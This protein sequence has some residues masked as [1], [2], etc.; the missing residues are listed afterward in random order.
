MKVVTEYIFASLFFLLP[1]LLLF[2]VIR[3][4]KKSVTS[5]TIENKTAVVTKDIYKGM[6]YLF[7]SV[8][9]FCFVKLFFFSDHNNAGICYENMGCPF[10]V[11]L[12]FIPEFYFISIFLKEI[13]FFFQKHTTLLLWVSFVYTCILVGVAM[14]ITLPWFISGWYF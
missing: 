13:S 12:I 3:S 8:V 2:L 14:L 9:Y 4:I 6:L 10:L 1:P 7:L 5:V 11:P